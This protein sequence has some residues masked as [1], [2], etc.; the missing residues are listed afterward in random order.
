MNQAKLL[1]RD[2]LER[3]SERR[4]ETV[5]A[6]EKVYGGSHFISA[7]ERYLSNFS[8]EIKRRIKILR[9]NGKN[10]GDLESISVS[11]DKIDP[12]NVWQLQRVQQRLEHYRGELLSIK[13]EKPILH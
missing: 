13:V 12:K 8:E 6:R 9:E 1:N 3:F 2:G 11:L 5:S 7:S 10:L 4:I